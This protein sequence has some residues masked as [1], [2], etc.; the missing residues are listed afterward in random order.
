MIRFD[1]VLFDT[2][3]VPQLEAGET[4]SDLLGEFLKPLDGLDLRVEAVYLDR[5][6][7]NSD[8]LSL[9]YAHNNAYVVPIVT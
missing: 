7:Y 5:G 3:A 9:L 8:C 6:F 2:L 4:T 1:I